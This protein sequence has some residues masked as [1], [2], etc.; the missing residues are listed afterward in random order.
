MKKTTARKIPKLT[1]AI[2]DRMRKAIAE[3][4]QPHVIA[5]TR[6]QAREAISRQQADEVQI[7]DLVAVIAAERE[8]QHLS[9]ENLKLRTG[10][11]RA[12][13]SRL[14]R[15]E[16]SPNLDTLKKLAAAVGKRLVVTLT[17]Q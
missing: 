10:I 12:N 9:L 14:F 16:G 6:Q 4:E 7:A 15:G 3:E 2:R 17:E 11:D 1:S 8:R 13:L 5:A